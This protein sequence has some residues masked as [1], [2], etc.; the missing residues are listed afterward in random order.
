MENIAENEDHREKNIL[1][2]KNLNEVKMDL[3]TKKR[4]LASMEMLLRMEKQR[5]TKLEHEQS[6]IKNRIDNLKKQLDDTFYKSTFGYI[7]LSKQLDEMHE[8]SMEA[9]G[10]TGSI[11]GN[12]A[13]GVHSTQSLFLAKIKRLS[14]SMISDNSV[15]VIE[16]STSSL[17]ESIQTKSNTGRDSLSFNAFR[18][19]LNSTFVKVNETESDL[20]CTFLTETSGNQSIDENQNQNHEDIRPMQEVNTNVT[21]R[22][23]R[24]VPSKDETQKVKNHIIIKR[25]VKKENH[26]NPLWKSMVLRSAKKVDYNETSFRRNK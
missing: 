26:S 25:R 11:D 23:D 14:E 6:F 16:P 3:R 15:A 9:S 1:L 13:V 24:K 21:I 10:S 5:N 22:K 12:S 17:N 4:N 19:G 8:E 20:D 2:A 18:M 7:S